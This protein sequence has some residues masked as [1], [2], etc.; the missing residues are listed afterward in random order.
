MKYSLGISNLL[1]EISS[2]SHSVVLCIVHFRLSYLSLLFSG[3]L[4]SVGY[5]F[6][7]LIC[8]SLLFSQLLVRPPQTTTLSPCI[9]FSWGWFR[10]PPLVQCYEPLSVVLQA[11]CL[12]DLTPWIYSSPPLQNHKGTWFRSYLNGLVVFS[13]FF[14]LS[15]NCAIEFI[16]WATVSSRSCCWLREKARE[17]QKNIYFCFID[18]PKALDCADHNKLWKILKRWEYQTT[19]HETCM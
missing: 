4:H 12:L 10:P 15:L 19:S 8:L 16:V 6:P 11:L 18:Y 2:L 5:I 1:D 9:S 17:F 13:T 14:N 3:T 7:F